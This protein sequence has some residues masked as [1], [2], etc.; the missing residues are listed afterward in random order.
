MKSLVAYGLL[1]QV[2]VGPRDMF[3]V[4]PAALMLCFL[5]CMVGIHNMSSHIIFERRPETKL[6]CNLP[7]YECLNG[8]S[9]RL[10]R[11]RFLGI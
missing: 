11:V 7:L 1:L 10:V 5:G 6:L 3:A 4:A 9:F 2:T 8:R